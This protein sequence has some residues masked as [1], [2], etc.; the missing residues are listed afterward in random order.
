MGDQLSGEVLGQGRIDNLSGVS[1]Q[2]Y[3]LESV[4]LLDILLTEHDGLN[5]CHNLHNLLLLLIILLI[6]FSPQHRQPIAFGHS[7]TLLPEGQHEF[8]AQLHSKRI[9]LIQ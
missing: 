5:I 4:A 7:L 8:T 2:T 3:S 6:E 1:Q 9:F